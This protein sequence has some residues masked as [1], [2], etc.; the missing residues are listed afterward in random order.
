MIVRVVAPLVN[1]IYAGI[2]RRA[3][4][5]APAPGELVVAH[6]GC[7]DGGRV[8]ENTVAAFARAQQGGAFGVELDVQFTRD[9]RAVVLHDADGGRV[10]GD[11]DLR[12]A[13]LPFAALREQCA[14]LPALAEV[15]EIFRGKLHLMIEVKAE[16]YA[17]H[18]NAA[19]AGD[20]Q[21]LTPCRDFHLLSLRADILA[22]LENFPAACKILVAETNTRQVVRE[23][24]ALG[25]GGVAGHF[26]LLHKRLRREL[27]ADGIKV[28][29]GFV[30][31]KNSLRR[32]LRIGA[33]WVFSNRAEAITHG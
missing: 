3:V 10:F 21:K 31:S 22:Q 17:P 1:R 9:G 7:H 14:E 8:R 23:A 24:R 20:L 4:A 29:V 16:S 28:G 12:P 25:I 19:L 33:D 11:A 27:R 30:D 26:L 2:P 32:E 13:E 18:C 15:A 5:A 6:R